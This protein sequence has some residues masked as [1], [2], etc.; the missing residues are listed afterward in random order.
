VE[1]GFAER[2]CGIEGGVEVV[3]GLTV[4]LVVAVEVPFTLL[5]N[6]I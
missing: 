2:F 6:K 3:A 5:A 4:I 1:T